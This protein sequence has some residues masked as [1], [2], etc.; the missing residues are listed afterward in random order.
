MSKSSKRIKKLSLATETLRS[1][2]NDVL[3]VVAGGAAR[4][5]DVPTLPN[6]GGPSATCDN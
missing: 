1:L 2:D 5:Q 6:C 4:L 3:S